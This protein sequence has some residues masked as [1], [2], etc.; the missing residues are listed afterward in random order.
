MV[1]VLRL[2]VVYWI[3]RLGHQYGTE[4]NRPI[5]RA[6]IGLLALAAAYPEIMR[7]M[8]VELD[9]LYQTAA[10]TRKK[11]IGELLAEFVQK[12]QLSFLPEWQI[13]RFH[14]DVN[15]LQ[16]MQVEDEKGQLVQVSFFS[17]DLDRLGQDNL[18]LVRSFSFVG[19]PTY[20]SIESNGES[21]KT[22]NASLLDG[23]NKHT[24]LG[25]NE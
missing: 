13:E 6:V 25:L 9:V 22:G 15:A 2:L 8:F 11:P 14:S 5:K 17:L 4:A 16:N 24:D 21:G 18:N 20:F 10:Q 1:N 3:R 23:E 19:D 7:E 12:P